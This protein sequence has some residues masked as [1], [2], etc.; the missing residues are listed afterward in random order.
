[1]NKSTEARSGFTLVELLVVIAIIGILIALLLPAVQSA[2]EAARRSS[3]SNKLRQL[4]VALH[5][6]H[7]AKEQFPVGGQGI[8]PDTGNYDS[9]HVVPRTPFCIFLFPYLEETSK[10]DLYNFDLSGI[11]QSMGNTM[12]EP[13]KIWTCPSDKTEMATGCTG[14]TRLEAKGNYGVNWGTD[15]Y[16]RPKQTDALWNVL[17]SPFWI[18]F[19]ANMRQITDGTSKTYAMLEMV[20]APS[21]GGSPCDRRGRIWNDDSSC[22]E[23]MTKFQ[24]NSFA[25]DNGK[26]FDQAEIDLPCKDS[27][28]G[29]GGARAQQFMSARS[30]HVGGVFALYCDSSIH[31]VG[32]DIELNIWQTMSTMAGGEAE[33]QA[34]ARSGR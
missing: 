22:Y 11:Q 17:R 31:F 7:D 27:G 34:I 25:Q 12:G 13:L 26:C 16:F 5:M 10:F 15:T 19:G 28:F 32:D 30:R 18:D 23:I 21:E 4:G 24:P 9:G 33:G 29:N 8:N 14:V 3:C 1:M 20:Q 6:H 2:R